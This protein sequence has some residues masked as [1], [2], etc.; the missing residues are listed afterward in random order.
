MAAIFNYFNKLNQF[1][2][3]RDHQCS[4]SNL[5]EKLLSNILCL[6]YFLWNRPSTEKPSLFAKANEKTEIFNPL[7]RLNIIKSYPFINGYSFAL[8]LSPYLIRWKYSLRPFVIVLCPFP[9]FG[10]TFPLSFG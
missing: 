8:G 3:L 1:D 4:L 7:I 9:L 2:F 5:R 10:P 6:K